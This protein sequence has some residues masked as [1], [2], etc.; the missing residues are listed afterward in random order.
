MALAIAEI[1]DAEK[2]D[3]DVVDAFLRLYESGRVEL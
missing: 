1:S 3:S 2:Y